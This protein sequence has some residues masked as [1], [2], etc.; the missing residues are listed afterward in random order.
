LFATQN[1]VVSEINKLIDTAP[2][3]LNTLSEIAAALNNDENFATTITGQLALKADIEDLA[4][5]AF[6]GSY[7]DLTDAPTVINANGT[8]SLPILIVEPTNLQAG[9]I[10]LADGVQW[11]P[12]TKNES[13]PYLAIYT[14]TGWI[15]VGGLTT[16]DVYK[17]IFEMG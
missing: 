16:T 12:L 7:N 9:Q 11:D 3:L 10:A 15:D 2:D 6:S 4:T 13:R 1:Y 17:Q 14:G 5:V 8:L